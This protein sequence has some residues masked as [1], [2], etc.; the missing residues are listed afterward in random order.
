MGWSERQDLN[1]RPPVP[2]TDALPGCATLRLWAA[3][4]AKIQLGQCTLVAVMQQIVQSR[5]YVFEFLS[6]PQQIY[7]FTRHWIGR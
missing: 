6:Q 4:T 7:V 1:L 3:Y 5:T 2:Q